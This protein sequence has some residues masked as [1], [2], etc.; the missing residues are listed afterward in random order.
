MSAILN[1]DLDKYFNDLSERHFRNMIYRFEDTVANA[2]EKQYSI[3]VQL[4]MKAF[5]QLEIVGTQPF[6]TELRKQFL[7]FY[8]IDKRTVISN[9]IPIIKEEQKKYAEEKEV[10]WEKR[11]KKL[12][13]FIPF[14]EW[15]QKFSPKTQT[16]ILVSG[17]FI[18]GNIYNVAKFLR[19]MKPISFNLR[20]E[21]PIAT[22]KDF[23]KIVKD[24]IKYLNINRFIK[25]AQHKRN[26]T[27]GVQNDVFEWSEL[28]TIGGVRSDLL[29][30]EKLKHKLSEG[31][32]ETVFTHL[33]NRTN[34]NEFRND[35]LTTK[36]R[37]I[38]N[39]KQ[40]EHGIITSSD[41][42]VENTKI[43][44]TLLGFI[45]RIQQ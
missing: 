14:I 25:Y 35:I 40:F 19:L 21:E 31:Q 39:K 27:E 43:V 38:T 18:V 42:N 1:T 12:E 17:L 3:T 29:E 37:F 7:H 23:K 26:I 34:E 22:E 36:Q 41:F 4:Q 13:K 45:D 32:I 11:F 33:L 28:Q 9:L 8:K 16:V 44:N 24:L 6:T 20:F 30:T 10:I 2:G 5:T 15:M